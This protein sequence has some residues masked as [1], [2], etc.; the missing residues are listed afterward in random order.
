MESVG[1]F[2]MLETAP[3]SAA[4]TAQQ[5][6]YL[7]STRGFRS[8]SDPSQCLRWFEEAGTFAAW[9]CDVKDDAAS[10]ARESYRFRPATSAD[11]LDVAGQ[12]AHPHG[13]AFCVDRAGG[14]GS[15]CLVTSDD[16]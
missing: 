14:H 7:A 13:H 15:S 11:H 3:C 10:A 16:A 5:W 1:S 9:A 6:V 2:R 4:A 8:V 12:A